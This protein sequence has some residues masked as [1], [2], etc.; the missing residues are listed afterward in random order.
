MVWGVRAGIPGRLGRKQARLKRGGQ[1]NV[2]GR[3][4]YSDHLP[5]GERGPEERQSG[6]GERRRHAQPRANRHGR[7]PY[8]DYGQ[9]QH[10]YP[11]RDRSGASRKRVHNQVDDNAPDRRSNH[12]T[13]RQRNP[14]VRLSK[15]RTHNDVTNGG[16]R[17]ELREQEQQP[18]D[19]R[20]INCHLSGLLAGAH[21]T[22]RCYRKECRSNQARQAPPRLTCPQGLYDQL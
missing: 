11:A 3:I 18:G 1:S 13:L 7:A 10:E 8:E 15:R 5:T 4:E 19:H 21:V 22:G 17:G 2:R 9:R 12:E 20:R 16:E 6:D 14:V